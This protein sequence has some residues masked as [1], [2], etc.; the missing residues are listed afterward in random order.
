MEGVEAVYSASLDPLLE[1][2]LAFSKFL[3]ELGNQVKHVVRVR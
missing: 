3:G 2:H 1:H